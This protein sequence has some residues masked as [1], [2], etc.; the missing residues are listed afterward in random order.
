MLCREVRALV[1]IS[2]V[3]LMR[4]AMA[5]AVVALVVV[6]VEEAVEVISVAEAAVV[7]VGEEEVCAM[8]SRE[9]SALAETSADSLTKRE[10]AFVARLLH[11][12][13]LLLHHWIGYLL[14]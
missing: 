14:L 7:E 9:E 8:P 13:L 4:V 11:Y 3:S 6:A 1:V 10:N 5:E 2:A 12:S